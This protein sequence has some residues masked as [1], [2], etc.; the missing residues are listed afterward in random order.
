[1]NMR[2]LAMTALAMGLATA[3]ASESTDSD[4]GGIGTDTQVADSGSGDGDSGAGSDIQGG[5]DTATGDDTAMDVGGDTGAPEDVGGDTGGGS[6]AVVINEVAPNPVAPGEDWVELFNPGSV[7]VDISGWTMTDDDPLHIYEFPAGTVVQ[8]GAY[9]LLNRGEIGSFDFGLGTDDAVF[10]YSGSKNLEAFSDWGDGDAPQGASWGRFPN[11]SGPFK[12]LLTPTPG[13]ANVDSAQPVCSNDLI[14]FGEVCD[15]TDLGD[16][17][18]EGLG[19]VGGTLACASDCSALSTAG[20]T[21]APGSVVVNEVVAAD[22]AG[23]PDWIELKN[24]GSAAVDLG[25]W[26]VTDSD[27]VHVATI[28]AG[29]V[30][31]AG[32][33]LLLIQDEPGSFAFGLGSADAVNLHNAKG[34]LTSTTSWVSGQ[35]PT[36]ASWGR[37]PDGTGAF[38]TLTSPTPGAANVENV[39]A[40]CNNDLIEFGELCDGASLGGTTCQ[41]VGF[42][43]GDLAC[44]ATC[45]GY[46]T[47]DCTLPADGVVINEVTSSGDDQIEIYNGGSAPASLAGWQVTD[48]APEAPDHTFTLPSGTTLAPGAYLVLTKGTHHIFGL[49]A[50]DAVRLVDSQGTLKNVVAWTSGQA[51]VSYC[52]IP[53]GAG[54]FKPCTVATFGSANIP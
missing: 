1:M 43:D 53:N 9:L 13:A 26:A 8:P 20:C 3:C 34:E 46:D 50:S 12:T 45:D 27:P 7:A 10:L 52:R 33:Y 36:G 44:N 32:S 22:G 29:T 49:G 48:D 11:G 40:T 25:G 51:E 38:M 15:G 30:L 6:G 31:E 21:L 41:S 42:D 18:C 37:Y 4:T 2:T 23:G 54:A 39:A 19:F 28:P 35:A 14:E 47:S 5:D 24:V 17:T 16:A